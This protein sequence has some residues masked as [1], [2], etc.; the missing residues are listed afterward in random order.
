MPRPFLTSEVNAYA[1]FNGVAVE[2]PV[3]LSPELAAVAREVEDRL[4]AIFPR[5][6]RLS[7]RALTI[8]AARDN[9]LSARKASDPFGKAMWLN[10]AASARRRAAQ[11]AEAA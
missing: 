10:Y 11:M 8:R 2:P 5:R 7:E 1:F 3:P 6:P 4:E 9:V